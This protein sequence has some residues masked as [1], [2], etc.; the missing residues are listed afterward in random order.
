MSAFVS[1]TIQLSHM[2]F[3][4]RE[5]GNS[6]A[7]PV[8]L[9]HALTAD[10]TDWDEVAAQLADR[11]HVYA[12][13]QRGHGETV[14]PGNYSFELMCDD[15]KAFVDAL[16]LK[17]F[18]LIG[19][20][21]GGGVA[22][23]FASKWPDRLERLVLEDFAPPG[24]GET[25]NVPAPPDEAPGPVTFDWGVLTSIARQLRSPDPAWW[26]D[27]PKINVPTLIIGGGSTSEIPQAW[28]ASASHRIPNCQFI[29]IEGAGHR[30]H[31]NLPNEYMA[32]LWQFLGERKA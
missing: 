9:L 21:M 8:I 18:T 11:F 13:D 7:P 12:L 25:L 6:E 14:Q 5:A 2:T 15:V 30:V 16:P 31:K 1:H 17:R 10:S 19:H 3:R 23:M 20:S 27:L 28:L 29:T 4:Y 26:N 24:P 22:T 32:S